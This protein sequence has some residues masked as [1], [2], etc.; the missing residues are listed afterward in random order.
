M[1]TRHSLRAA[2][3]AKCHHCTVD[4]LDVGTAAQ[5]IACCTISDCPLHPVRPVT[6]TTSPQR[7]LAVWGI[8][9]DDLCER[10]S[11]LV[12]TELAP[13]ETRN[14]PEAGSESESGHPHEHPSQQA[15]GRSEIVSMTS[16]DEVA[17]EACD[18]S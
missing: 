14:G 11:Q 16:H 5:Q 3:N 2:I 6:T 4:P 17:T 8:S 15:A 12:E 18:A 13:V 1:N 9:S 10:A 7:L